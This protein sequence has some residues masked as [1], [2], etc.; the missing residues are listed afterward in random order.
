MDLHG[1]TRTR[2][3]PCGGKQNPRRLRTIRRAA[4]WACVEPSNAVLARAAVLWVLPLMLNCGSG[5]ADTT[6]ANAAAG[7][8]ATSPRLGP[9]ASAG[10]GALAS[11]TTV[12]AGTSTGSAGSAAKGSPTPMSNGNFQP[13][14]MPP[15][16]KIA[17]D[18]QE[19]TPGKNECQPGT[20]SGTFTCNYT[21][22]G[23]DPSAPFVATGPVVFTLMKSQNGEFLEISD[24]HI[25]GLA[26]LIF[27]FNSKLQGRL[28]CT[29]NMFTAMA[30]EGTYG[31]GDANLLPVGLFQGTLSGT[32]DRSSATLSGEWSLMVT[33]GLGAGGTCVGPWT[34]TW[35]P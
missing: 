9:A 26:D 7:T 5:G 23:I 1:D 19:T 4:Q 28:D 12:G 10:S 31:L 18:W 34:A 27:D 2:P 6:G 8:G 11:Q 30:V 14:L 15:D 33:D 32:L 21:G 20:Y 16:P 25:Q 29:T 24:G 13:R 22:P 35:T 17:F 3:R